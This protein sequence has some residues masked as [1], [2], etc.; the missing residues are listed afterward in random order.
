MTR[1][2]LLIEYEGG[3]FCGWQRQENGPSVQQTIEDAIH[4]FSGETVKL[5]VAGRTDAGVHALGQVAHFDLEKETD[6][7]TV[8]GAINFHV[9]PHRISILKAE[10]AAPDFNAR[11][12][13]LSRVYRYL[14]VNRSAPLAL[15]QGRA[16]LFPRPLTLAPMQEAARILIG[17]KMDFSTFRAQGCQANSPMRTLDRLDI[18]QDGELFAFDVEA[19]SFLYHQ[20]RN[21][22]GTLTL[23]GA[24]QWSVA[25]FRAAFEAADRTR[26]GPT[27]PAEGLYF[28]AVRYL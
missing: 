19:R 10:T 23:V 21:M 26:G 3:G 25:D 20:V 6:A 14:V 17:R 22:V 13:A 9:R 4:K 24:G 1:W 27:A 7:K 16:W 5:Y 2:K 12:S 11:M 8:E 28:A 15:M 18:S